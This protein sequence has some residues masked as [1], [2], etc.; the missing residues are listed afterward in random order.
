MI[1]IAV[2]GVLMAIAAPNFAR[3][4]RVGKERTLKADILRV[5]SAMAAFYSDT[6]CLPASLTDLTKAVAPSTCLNTASASKP[7]TASTFKG[8]YIPF[9]P[10]DAVSGSDLQYRMGGMPVVRSSA[11]GTD[12][13][14]NSFDGY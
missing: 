2:I 13:N 11:S 7:L 3:S 4:M 8:P 5:R 6:G 14:G 12:S 10:H 9:I 1:V